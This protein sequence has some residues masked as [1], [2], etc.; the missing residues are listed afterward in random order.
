MWRIALGAQAH[1]RVR[2]GGVMAG[3]LLGLSARMRTYVLEGVIFY[4]RSQQLHGRY[5]GACDERSYHI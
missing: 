5:G 4:D 2:S 1:R 3:V